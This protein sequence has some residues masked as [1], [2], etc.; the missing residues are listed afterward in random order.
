[1]KV[2][3]EFLIAIILIVGL[4]VVMTWAYGTMQGIKNS[5]KKRKKKG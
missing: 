2:L 3:I 4:T 5:S 1:M